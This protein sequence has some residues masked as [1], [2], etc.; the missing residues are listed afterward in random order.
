MKPR[1]LRESK[2]LTTR[3]VAGQLGIKPQTLTKKERTESFT[4][5]NALQIC[6]L[7]ELYNVRVEDLNI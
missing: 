3:F 5:F 2:G 6:K 4:A 1:E 7:C